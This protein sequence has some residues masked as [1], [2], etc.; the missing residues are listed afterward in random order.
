MSPEMAQGWKPLRRNISS[1]HWGSAG[2]MYQP[3]G[4]SAIAASNAARARTSIF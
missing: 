1:G 4:F 3:A 2:A